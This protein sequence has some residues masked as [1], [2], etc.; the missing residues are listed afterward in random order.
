MI[1]TITSDPLFLIL[2]F[3]IFT[4]AFLV[5]GLLRENRKESSLIESLLADIRD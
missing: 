2:L 4:F 5:I 3:P 1:E